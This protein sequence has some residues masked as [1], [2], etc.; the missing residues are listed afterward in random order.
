MNYYGTSM[1][2][3]FNLVLCGMKKVFTLE[4]KQGF[5]SQE[6][7][8]TSLLKKSILVISDKKMLY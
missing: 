5:F 8:M 6:I 2:L 7:W 3:V 1:L 4:S